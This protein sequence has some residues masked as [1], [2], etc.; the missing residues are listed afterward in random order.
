MKICDV[1]TWFVGKNKYLLCFSEEGIIE[2]ARRRL[3]EEQQ[4]VPQ[5]DEPFVQIE[6]EEAAPR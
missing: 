2:A 4:I 6:E 3:A 5:V 1:M